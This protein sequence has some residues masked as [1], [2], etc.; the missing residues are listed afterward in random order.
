MHIFK[1]SSIPLLPQIPYNVYHMPLDRLQSCFES[2]LPPAPTNQLL[3]Q[4]PVVAITPQIFP[5]LALDPRRL[6][7]RGKARRDEAQFLEDRYTRHNVLGAANPY[8]V[9]FCHA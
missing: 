7:R 5:K 6:L 9:G 1:D 8:F 4:G 3:R 2:C